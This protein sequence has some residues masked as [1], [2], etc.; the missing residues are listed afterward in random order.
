MA[1]YSVSFMNGSATVDSASNETSIAFGLNTSAGT[2]NASGSSNDAGFDSWV[3]LSGSGTANAS[4]SLTMGVGY[5]FDTNAP[6]YDTTAYTADPAKNVIRFRVN[7]GTV[8]GVMPLGSGSGFNTGEIL[9]F[10]VS[11][12]DA[13]QSFVLKGYNLK[14]K[15][16]ERVDLYYGPSATFVDTTAAIMD[17]SS[18]NIVLGN[19]DQFGLAYNYASGTRSTVEGISF[20]VIPEPATIGMF[21]GL[22]LGLFWVRRRFR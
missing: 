9:H 22:G 10:T 15:N 14:D 19:G 6:S 20:D 4:F 21:A 1:D 13:G 12:L 2:I 11:G 8:Q 5:G 3:G 16:A 17:V 18:E 7:K